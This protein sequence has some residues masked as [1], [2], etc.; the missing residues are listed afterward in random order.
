MSKLH[1]M[2][3]LPGVTK[4]LPPAEPHHRGKSPQT[5]PK[6]WRA[7]PQAECT[8][9]GGWLGVG[10]SPRAF[11][12]RDQILFQS[13]FSEAKTGS[14]DLKEEG[15]HVPQSLGVAWGLS[16]LLKHPDAPARL[17]LVLGGWA[18]SRTQWQEVQE[19]EGNR[20]REN[21]WGLKTSL[22]TQHRTFWVECG[23]EGFW[24]S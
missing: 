18:F 10:G 8:I 16:F 6:G 1:R 19:P 17:P 13:R 22:H 2:F 21:K 11:P 20:P 15:G 3:H 24:T 14:G 7:W 23:L 4:H 9:Q 12:T 5:S